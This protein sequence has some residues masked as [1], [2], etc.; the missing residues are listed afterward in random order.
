MDILQIRF[1]AISTMEKNRFLTIVIIFLLILNLGTLV[2]VFVSRN[3]GHQRPPF[4]EGGPANFITQE[5]GFDEQ[6]KTRFNELKKE[7]Q[8]QMRNMQ[9]S[10]K[11]QR[12]Q[13]PEIIISDN[14]AR[15]DSIT[16]VIGRYQKQ[17]E[18]YTYQHFVKVYALCNEDQKK[19]FSHIIEDILKMMSP[20]KGGPPP[21]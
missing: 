8:T 16:T 14:E 11:I 13:F 2:F 17:I 15:A 12:D 6:Q 5:L 10:M 21:H 1:T 7:H 4:R 18:M 19:K 9:D 20:G 3:G